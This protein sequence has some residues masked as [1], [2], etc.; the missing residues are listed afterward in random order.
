M[1]PPPAPPVAPA[2]PASA[3]PTSAA[4]SPSASAVR[5]RWLAWR[6]SLSARLVLLF[7]LLALASSAIFI[8]GVQRAFGAGWRAAVRPLVEDYVDRL[9]T[10]IGTPPDVARAQALTERL[11]LAVRIEG[12]VVNWVSNPQSPGLNGRPWLHRHPMAPPPLH[13]G[14]DDAPAPFPS[15]SGRPGH[16]ASPPDGVMGERPPRRRALDPERA[17]LARTTA[18]GHVIQF[19]LDTDVWVARSRLIGGAT[20]ALLLALLALT[21]WLVRR[22]LIRPIRQIGRGAERF[23]QGDFSQPIELGRRD[24]LGELAGRV[25]R[26]AT[27]LSGMLESQ[28]SLLLAISHELRSPL[29]RARLNAE[30]LDD[31]NERE[32]LLRDLGLMRDLI[33]DLLESE[34]L[35]RPHA[36]LQRETTDAAALAALVASVREQLRAAF[37]QAE[38]LLRVQ[39][40]E[41]LALPAA[42]VDRAR[43]ALLLRNLLG[44]AWRHAA[45]A[46]APPELMLA[47]SPESGGQLRLSVRDHGPGV[48]PEAIARLAEPF[49]RPDSARTRGAGG[50]GLGLHLCRRVAEAHG[51]T[52]TLENAAPGLRVTANLPWPGAAPAA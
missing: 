43:I 50:V 45:D 12:P 4:L 29:T 39:L 25:N 22:W 21:W 6:H 23:G 32:A 46:P 38:P 17:W 52:L 30:L 34:R 47:W 48:P 40:P 3:S 5:Q 14:P 35:A 24:E 36:A 27:D 49:Y 2:A 42:A 44:N 28:R 10:E 16:H 8:S 13:L 9:A 15:A 18:D 37:P 33:S 19:A 51:G 26:M 11:P 7:V 1:T 41:A 20:L 31:G